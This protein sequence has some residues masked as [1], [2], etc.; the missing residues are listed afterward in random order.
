MLKKIWMISMLYLA[1]AGLIEYDISTS[2]GAENNSTTAVQNT[3]DHADNPEQINPNKEYQKREEGLIL[4]GPESFIGYNLLNPMM[5]SNTYLMDNAGKIVN[6]WEC[7]SPGQAAYLLPN[8]HLLRCLTSGLGGNRTFHAGGAGGRIQE[9]TWDGELVWDYE[10]ANDDHLLHHGVEYMPNGNI[11]M[12]AWER[13]KVDETVASGRSPE[14]QGDRDLWVDHIIEVKSTGKTTGDIV[15]EWHVWDHLVQNFDPDKANYGNVIEHPE[16]VHVNP[17]DWMEQVL[18]EDLEKLKSLGYIGGGSNSPNV[19]QYNR[20]NPFNMDAD[21]MHTNAV[22]YNPELDQIAIS[23]MG[24]SEVW[25]IDHST[26]TKEAAGHSGGKYG[27]GGDLLYRWGNPLAY[28]AGAK[29]DQ[30]L[31]TQHDV[32]WIPRNIKGA[33]HLLVFNNGRGRL[34]GEYS[35]AVEITLPMD[36]NGNYMLEPGKAY[37]PEKPS[38]VYT[39]PNKTDFFSSF[40]SAVERLPN[41]NTLICSGMNGTLFEVTEKGDVVWKYQLPGGGM[42]PGGPGRGGR[43]SPIAMA[44][45]D[46]DSKL[47]FKEASTLPFFNEDFFKQLDKNADGLLEKD[48]LPENGPPPGMFGTGMP[49]PGMPG[50]DR[51]GQGRPDRGRYVRGPGR[52]N[53][54]PPM[55]D[56]LD[57]NHDGEVTLKEATALPFFDEASFKQFDKN[58]D[59]VLKGDEIPNAPPQGMR[60][61][62]RFG[63]G[64]P[65]PGGMPGGGGPGFGGG[66]FTAR[67]YAPDFPGLREKNLTPG[68]TLEAVLKNRQ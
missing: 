40:L 65:G 25:V 38:W 8:G 28:G 49:G 51:P 32:Q 36:H 54:F 61:P 39:A 18:P 7:D 63:R 6:K 19:D 2:R 47:T 27:K 5:S 23:V 9:Y 21:W 44:D 57:A 62:G 30:Q 16:L 59:G 1:I 10:Y 11:L 12:I 17:I 22:S 53:N 68:D 34:D 48:E 67:R 37:G 45:S 13:K 66:I 26:T 15:W 55:A 20:G 58:E 52:N 60:G 29:E 46:D 33:G 31:F 35:S 41:G 43:F 14:I 50:Q 64:M 4:N 42:G 24:F 56:V 3:R